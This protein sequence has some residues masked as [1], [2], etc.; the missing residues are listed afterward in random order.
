MDERPFLTPAAQSLPVLAAIEAVYKSAATGKTEEI[1]T[2]F[3]EMIN[4]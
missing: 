4:G 2:R 1:D 3:L